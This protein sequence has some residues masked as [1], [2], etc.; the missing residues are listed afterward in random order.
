MVR[1]MQ[2]LVRCTAS[3]RRASRK[4]V[5]TASRYQP[6]SD[7]S[8][9]E[10]KLPLLGG[11]CPA[12]FELFG[13]NC[14]DWRDLTGLADSVRPMLGISQDAWNDARAILG[15]K[16]SAAAL[17]IIVQKQALG[18]IQSPGGYLRAMTE[19]HRAGQLRLD[20]TLKTLFS[21]LQGSSKNVDPN[22]SQ[23]Y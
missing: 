4:P 11:A 1:S 23:L 14:H 18:E 13:G 10:L 21:S 7:V 5:A 17:A 2:I 6:L 12:F 19:R 22:P 3:S 8:E 9:I 20:L 15:L 16:L